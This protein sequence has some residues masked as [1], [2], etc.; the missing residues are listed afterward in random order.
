[1]CLNGST[2]LFLGKV[3]YSI[4]AK[5]FSTHLP[6]YLKEYQ[7]RIFKLYED[8]SFKQVLSRSRARARVAAKR[9]NKNIIK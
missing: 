6:Y 4:C 7:I 9:E 2:K 5:V 8:L 1:M 3:T